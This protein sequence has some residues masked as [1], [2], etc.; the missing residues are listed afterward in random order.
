MRTGLLVRAF[1]VACAV[2]SI[3]SA[4]GI[5]IVCYSTSEFW[6]R[7]AGP[8]PIVLAPGIIIRT[9]T[10]VVDVLPRTLHYSSIIA[11]FVSSIVFYTA[12]TYLIL[13]RRERRMLKAGDSC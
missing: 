7:L 1:L 2:T 12:V 11:A 4:S 10:G 9:L 3:P 8:L 13:R 5:L 6:R